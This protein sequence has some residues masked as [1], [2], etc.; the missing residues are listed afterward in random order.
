M[1]HDQGFAHSDS[2]SV[3]RLLRGARHHVA[4]DERALQ[5]ASSL[6]KCLERLG[7]AQ[8]EAGSQFR[9]PTW[10]HYLLPGTCISRKSGASGG[11]ESTC[12]NVECGLSNRGLPP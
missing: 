9:S 1:V 11:T 10:G 8:A 6:P 12:S 3:G 5:V 7:L 2:L 4:K